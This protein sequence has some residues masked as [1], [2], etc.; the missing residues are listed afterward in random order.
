MLLERCVGPVDLGDKPLVQ[1]QLE[2]LWIKDRERLL[3]CA[4][5]HLALRDYYADRDA[6]LAGGKAVKK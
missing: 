2:K 6:V 4:R 5:G 3:S 1:A